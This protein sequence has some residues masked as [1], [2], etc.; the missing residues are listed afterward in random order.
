MY[1]IMPVSWDHSVGSKGSQSWYWRQGKVGFWNPEECD[2]SMRTVMLSMAPNGSC[3]C[4][5]S[6]TY[7]T[8][9]SSSEIN[10]CSA[11][12]MMPMSYTH[13]RAHETPEH[14]VCRLL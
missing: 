13:L 1:G 14:L 4:L 6:G 11:S 10:L 9:G 3:T 12:C 2:N 8:M 7:L 5:S